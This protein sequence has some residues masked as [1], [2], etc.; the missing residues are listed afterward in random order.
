MNHLTNE[1][2]EDCLRGR[3]VDLTHLDQCQD[4][5]DRL[6]EKRAI[7][8][9]LRL[10]FASV[11]ADEGLAD[12]IRD[13]INQNSE[14]A[15]STKSIATRLHHK[16]WPALT[17]AAAVFVLLVPLSMYLLTPSTATAAQAELVMI[18]QQNLGSHREFFSDTDPEKLAGY[19]KDKLGFVPAFPCTGQGMEIRGCCVAHFKDKIV[20][21]YVVDTD[22]GVISIIVVT[23]TPKQLG[24]THMPG[25]KGYDQ[26]LWKSSYAQCNMVTV[27]LG[28]YSYC[29][30]GEVSEISYK[31][32]RDLLSRLLP[33]TQQ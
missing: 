23:D 5:R 12:R 1:Q 30:I 22:K 19:F 20:G 16:L 21:S 27:R 7:A 33:N 17:A 6:A 2:L 14:T 8:A 24:M 32:L 25:K 3:D 15:D 18:H 10:A 4:C 28:D 31:Y 29:A 11:K 26:S 13:Q 9:K